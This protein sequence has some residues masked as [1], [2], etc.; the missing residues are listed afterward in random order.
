VRR[1]GTGWQSKVEVGERTIYRQ[2]DHEPTAA[3]LLAWCVEQRTANAT[4]TP[5]AG[6]FEADVNDYL[7]RVAAMPTIGHVRHHL[8]LWL[9]ALGRTRRRSTITAA[10]ID[11]VM[12]RWLTTPVAVSVDKRNGRPRSADGVL[13]LTTIHKRRATLRAMFYRL[14]GK[15]AVNPV[16]GTSLPPILAAAPRGR[17]YALIARVLDAMPSTR[18][19]RG[20]PPAL[21]RSRAAVMAYTGLPPALIRQ[22]KPTD[23]DWEAALLRVSARRKGRGVEA[24]VLPLAPQALDA[25]RAFDAA[26]AYGSFSTAS[27]NV[28]F[29]RAAARIGV[30]PTTIT[31]YDLRHSFGEQLYRATR[32]LQ[33]V[34][35]MLCHSATSRSTARYA[36][37]ANDEV[38]QLAARAFSDA[39]AQLQASTSDGAATASAPA[40][41][42][43]APPPAVSPARGDVVA[44]TR[45]SPVLGARGRTSSS[46]ATRT[47]SLVGTGYVPAIRASKGK[48]RQVKH[49]RAV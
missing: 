27:F 19:R 40:G 29:K 30:D 43:Q 14:D 12:Q 26:N 24:R 7:A 9:D 21:A 23:I 2:W 41:A 42:T 32:D 44:P 17:D 25:L 10:E 46:A 1:K 45:T 38:N 49:L 31:V 48:S 16:R 39:V 18:C 5:D 33:T 3:E 6:S 37:G 47:S 8:S 13:S 15:Q 11:V 4:T 36:A 28:C 20:A 35:R 34:G 22:I